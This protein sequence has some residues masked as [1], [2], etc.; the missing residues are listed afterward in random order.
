MSLA[1]HRQ[2]I[3]RLDREI[4]KLLNER[5]THACAIGEHKLQ[6]GQEIYAP[7]REQ[8]VLQR[9]CK[10]NVGRSAMPPCARSIARS[11]PAPSLWR[12]R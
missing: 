3:D 1:E 6:N 11:C 7:H 5:T 10:L 9:I 4:V 12:R 8:A 2:A